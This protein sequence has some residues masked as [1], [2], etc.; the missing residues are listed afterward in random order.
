ME[1]SWFQMKDLL[2]RKWGEKV[3]IPL[4]ISQ[5][6][7][8]Q[9]ERKP[10]LI[11]EFIGLATLAVPLPFQEQAKKIEWSDIWGKEHGPTI[12]NNKYIPTG[13]TPRSYSNP[14]GIGLV[15]EQRIPGDEPNLWHLNQDMVFALGLIREGNVWLRPEENYREAVKFTLDSNNKVTLIEIRQ[16]LLKDYLCA[17][18]LG[19]KFV[20]YQERIEIVLQK[21]S[22]KWADKSL[23]IKDVDNLWLGRSTKIDS[24]GMPVGTVAVVNVT[25]PTADPKKDVPIVSHEDET[26]SSHSTFTRETVA[27]RLSGELWQ[28]EWLN[29]GTLST[30]VRGDKEPPVHY[31]IDAS[32]SRQSSIDLATSGRWIWFKAEVIPNLE[33]RRGGGLKW[34]T[35]E[36][37]SVW[38]S[39]GHEVTF[40]LNSIGLITVYAKDISYL[41]EWQ[42]RLWAGFNISPEGGLS[43]EMHRAQ[44]VGVPSGTY[45]PETLFSMACDWLEQAFRMKEGEDIFLVNTSRSS[46]MQQISRFSGCDHL[47]LLTLAKDLARLTADSIN[48]KTIAKILNTDDKLGSLKILELYLSKLIPLAEAKKIM[49]PLFCIYDLRLADAHLPSSGIDGRF[50]DLGLNTSQPYVWQSAQMINISANAIGNIGNIISESFKKSTKA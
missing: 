29:P 40:G 43:G 45:A 16:E 31:L 8:N 1:E 24:F 37:G 46:I 4:R 41:P 30:R 18:K 28:S 48:K 39:P 27:Y 5:S 38:C 49:S 35:R 47:G 11:E 10:G 26:H 44:V 23:E 3:W 7:K 17:R 33:I 12:Y 32:G 14:C 42:Q 6:A 13:I 36:M 21:P 15:L 50:T 22:F 9:E 25:R 19:L 34:H 20:S 2:T